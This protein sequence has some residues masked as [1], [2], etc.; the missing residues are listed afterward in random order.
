MYI[1]T[2]L[3]KSYIYIHITEKKQRINLTGFLFKSKFLSFQI[4][5]SAHLLSHYHYCYNY[6]F[7]FTSTPFVLLL[8]L[9]FIV[10]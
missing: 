9:I 2:Y 7:C 4:C 6:Y 10:L 8:F 5:D 3:S 1:H